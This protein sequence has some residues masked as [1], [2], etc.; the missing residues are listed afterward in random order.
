MANIT[1]SKHFTNYVVIA[2]GYLLAIAILIWSLID[3]D[4][5]YISDF[6]IGLAISQFAGLYLL[7]SSG[8]FKKT[9]YY[10]FARIGIAIILIGELLKLLHYSGS[11][12]TVIAGYAFILGCYTISF[13]NKPYKKLLDWLKLIYALMAVTITIGKF[14]HHS[15]ANYPQAYFI[16]MLIMVILHI[17]KQKEMGYPEDVNDSFSL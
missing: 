3:E 17:K 8:T 6:G 11:E 10:R 4:S 9:R 14:L 12:I 15:I 1:H 16:I 7:I 2:I 13:I 5:L